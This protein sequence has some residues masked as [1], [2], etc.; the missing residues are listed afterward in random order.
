M[1]MNKSYIVIPKILLITYY[2]DLLCFERYRDTW[3]QTIQCLLAYM[4]KIVTKWKLISSAQ[5]FR[6]Q[7]WKNSHLG[8]PIMSCVTLDKIYNLSEL[9]FP[10]LKNKK[11]WFFFVS[12]LLS[13][14]LNKTKPSSQGVDDRSQ[15][16]TYLAL[17]CAWHTCMTLSQ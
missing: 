3:P 9:Y 12:E 13:Y 16:C 17:S 11:Y 10:H 1:L 7:T 5:L 14:N 6:A 15:A 2:I 8:S 4:C